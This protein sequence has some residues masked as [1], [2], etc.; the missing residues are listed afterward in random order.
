METSFFIKV[1]NR[2]KISKRLI[3]FGFNY[4]PIPY[5]HDLCRHE[6]SATQSV[7]QTLKGMLDGSLLYMEYE[8]GEEPCHVISNTKTSL[9]EDTEI[10]DEQ[11][12]CWKV[13]GIV[14]TKLLLYIMEQWKT[15]QEEY[16]NPEGY[17]KIVK[18]AFELIKKNPDKYDKYDTKVSFEV[19]IDNI[20]VCLQILDDKEFELSADEYIQE[21][22]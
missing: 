16:R 14:D 18:E 15:F 11:N 7:V 12:E 1:F 6:L 19:Q 10:W 13:L 20:Y 2:D 5:L 9:I 3:R 4:K 17:T 21:I 22:G 8:W